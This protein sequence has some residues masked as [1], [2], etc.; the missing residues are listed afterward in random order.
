MGWRL[1][2][3][4]FLK[5][6]LAKLSINELKMRGGYGRTGN[7]NIGSFTYV[8]SIA[9]NKNYASGSNTHIGSQQTG[10]ANPDLTWEK[11][12]QTSVGADIGFMQNKKLRLQPIILSAIQTGCC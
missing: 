8:N 3:E 1:A 4:T 2:E 10:F 11:N 12:D 5:D 7:A 6:G 9:L